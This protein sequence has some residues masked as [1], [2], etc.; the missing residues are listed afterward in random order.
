MIDPDQP[1]LKAIE[2]QLALILRVKFPPEVP[3]LEKSESAY[4]F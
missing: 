1:L 3:I 2:I 4:L